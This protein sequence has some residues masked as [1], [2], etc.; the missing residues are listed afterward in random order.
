MNKGFHKGLLLILSILVLILPACSGVE[1]SLQSPSAVV[2]SY[3]K[4]WVAKNDVTLSMLSCSEWEM[5]AL[6]DLDSFQAFEVRL[7]GLTCENVGSDGVN[8]LVKCQG[9]IIA[10]YNGEDQ[11]IDLSSRTYKVIDQSGEF[12][13]CGYQ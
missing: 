8:S 10:T 2:E 6:M 11:N 3:I 5:D 12:L 4:S 7:D 9:T 13:V 1:S